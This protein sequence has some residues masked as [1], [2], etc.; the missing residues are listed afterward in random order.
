MSTNSTVLSKRSAM[1]CVAECKQ[2]VDCDSVNYRQLDNRCEKNFLPP[3]AIDSYMAMEVLWDNLVQIYEFIW[4]YTCT[5][6]TGSFK[7]LLHLITC[8]RTII[9]G[10]VDIMSNTFYSL[11][12][13]CH[14]K[15]AEM[16]PKE[17]EVAIIWAKE[18]LKSLKGMNL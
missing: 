17:F 9:L 4:I 14:L 8:A 13:L 12:N 5:L 7:A 2:T 11:L 18:L 15:L 16:Q 6:W 1:M 3:G 10:C